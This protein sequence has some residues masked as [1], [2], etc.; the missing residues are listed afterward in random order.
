MATV[1]LRRLVQGLVTV[2]VVT[3]L[4]FALIHAAPGEPFASVLSDPRVTPA[5]RAE[6]RA[7]Y[8]LDQPLL[9]QYGHFLANVARGD[10]GVSFTYQRPV[11]EVLRDALPSTLLLM[12]TAIAI[13]F[14][15]GIALGAAQASRAGGWF[16]RLTGSASVI[17]AALP[18]FWLATVALFL[19]A[20][21]WH[22]TPSGGMVD[23]VL[24][25][26][27]PWPGRVLDVLRHLALPAT[28]LGLIV[29]AALARYQR[30]ALLE[31]LPNEYVRTAR[32]KGVARAAILYRHALR[33]ALL[34]TI[35]LFGLAIPALLGGAVF[36]ESIFGWPGM[37]RLAVDAVATRD[38]PLVL[39]TV[40]VGSITVVAGALVADIL[41]AAADPRMRRA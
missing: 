40:M 20:L 4:T 26:S 25:E 15:G 12:L 33:N 5:I 37:G 41:Y 14:L 24:H 31:T 2:F 1:I 11:G 39:A 27:L 16:D 19:F 6:W 17:V 32:A 36:I 35:T 29:G 30:A 10:L 13:A 18:D 38:Y 22:L 34:P 3:T 9:S 8:G 7:H 28:T 21:R 23:Q